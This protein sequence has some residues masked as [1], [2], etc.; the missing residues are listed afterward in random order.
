VA[1]VV[2]I[3]DRPVQFSVG[4]RYYAEAAEF[5]PDGW[6]GRFQMTLLFPK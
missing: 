1:Q 3:G 6:G 2:K 5:G 4:A